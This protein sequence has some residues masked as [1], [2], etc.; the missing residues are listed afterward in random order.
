VVVSA[1]KI[2]D[3][4]VVVEAWCAWKDHEFFEAKFKQVA[5]SLHENK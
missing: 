2:G 4:V 1:I 5:G 3:K